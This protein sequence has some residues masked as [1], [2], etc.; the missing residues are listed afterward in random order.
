MQIYESTGRFPFNKFYIIRTA[1]LI[2]LQD[3]YYFIFR[4]LTNAKDTKTGASAVEPDC[5]ELRS[6]EDYTFQTVC[7]YPGKRTYQDLYKILKASEN[8]RRERLLSRIPENDTAY[9]VDEVV[10]IEY[11]TAKTPSDTLTISLLYAGGET[12]VLFYKRNDS[13][14]MHTIYMPD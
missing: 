4:C 9:T 11:K 7:A 1:Y 5:Q 2:V 14:V 6:E 3:G 8:F 13:T 10:T 12:K